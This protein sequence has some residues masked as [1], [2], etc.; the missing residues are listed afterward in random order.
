GQPRC[1]NDDIVDAHAE[2]EW[3]RGL[4]ACAIDEQ[5]AVCRFE[6]DDV[7]T[8][9]RLRSSDEPDYFGSQAWRQASPR[10]IQPGLQLDQCLRVHTQ[11]ERGLAERAQR[12][13][14]RPQRMRAQK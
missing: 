13:R 2:E 1:P 9:K 5:L 7:A 8:D 3:R 4:V 12:A 11:L 6:R 14:A 10:I